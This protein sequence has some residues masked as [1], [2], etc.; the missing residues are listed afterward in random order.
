MSR[1]T[2]CYFL[3][4]I[5]L[6][7]FH[8]S[9]TVKTFYFQT[10]WGEEIRVD[11]SG[12]SENPHYIFHNVSNERGYSIF[13]QYVQSTLSGQNYVYLWMDD[14]GN[15]CFGSLGNHDTDKVNT[16]GKQRVKVKDNN[17]SSILNKVVESAAS[18]VGSRAVDAVATALADKALKESP[19]TIVAGINEKPILMCRPV[20]NYCQTISDVTFYNIDGG[21]AVKYPISNPGSPDYAHERSIQD[22]LNAFSF[23]ISVT[24]KTTYTGSGQD[25]SAQM[26]CYTIH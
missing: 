17:P 26:T 14:C 25:L 18:A 15:D 9:A 6:A 13:R 11:V 22:A 12:G 4:F 2:L 21:W 5:F 23:S 19:F 3:F 10:Q 16:S 20:Q 24:C 7:P 8:A 1:Y